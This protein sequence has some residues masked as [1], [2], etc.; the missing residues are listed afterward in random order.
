VILLGGGVQGRELAIRGNFIDL[1]SAPV[2]GYSLAGGFGPGRVLSGWLA[3]GISAT[4]VYGERRTFAGWGDRRYVSGV[5]ADA[6]GGRGRGI[7]AENH[8]GTHGG[9][10]ECGAAEFL[11]T[12]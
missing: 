11:G 4:R 9:S 2:A 6:R 3:P 5:I 8:T 1:P 7:H 10:V 12:M